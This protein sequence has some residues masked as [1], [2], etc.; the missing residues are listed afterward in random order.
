MKVESETEH[1]ERYAVRQRP[2]QRRRQRPT[3]VCRNVQGQRRTSAPERWVQTRQGET[4]RSRQ[5]Q[6]GERQADVPQR[7]RKLSTEEKGIQRETCRA[8]PIVCHA[9]RGE[10]GGSGNG[11]P[12]C[13]FLGQRREVEE[14]KGLQT[15][16]PAVI[17]AG[18]LPAVRPLLAVLASH[19]LGQ[20]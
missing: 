2:G 18:L 15:G 5:T 14:T 6:T 1:V 8:Q 20:E 17:T 13:A 16:C 10:G 9:P 12:R 7:I 11:A 4:K 3:G 19:P